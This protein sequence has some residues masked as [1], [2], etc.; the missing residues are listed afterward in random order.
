MQSFTRSSV[1]PRDCRLGDVSLSRQCGTRLRLVIW[2]SAA[3]FGRQEPEV[4]SSHSDHYTGHVPADLRAGTGPET[5]EGAANIR[6]RL[7]LLNIEGNS[8]SV[9]LVEGYAHLLSERSANF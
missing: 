4:Q 5:P 9:A 8:S 6:N 3:L 1:G 7:P 2:S